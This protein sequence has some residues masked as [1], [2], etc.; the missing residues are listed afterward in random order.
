MKTSTFPNANLNA[1]GASKALDLEHE[2]ISSAYLRVGDIFE[3]PEGGVVPCD[4]ILVEGTA[5]IDEADVTGEPLPISKVPVSDT[6]TDLLDL[7]KHG[8]RHFLH[9]GTVVIQ[10]E[11]PTM[12]PVS[13]RNKKKL[14]FKPPGTAKTR[15]SSQINEMDD[16]NATQ[17]VRPTTTTRTSSTTAVSSSKSGA[18]GALALV[19]NVG[20]DTNKGQMIAKIMF[21]QAVKCQ[22]SDNLFPLLVGWSAI[23]MTF[24]LLPGIVTA[25]N[26]K[27]LAFTAMVDSIY[28]TFV[29]AFTVLNPVLL[30]CSCETNGYGIAVQNANSRLRPN[31]DRW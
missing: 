15:T 24:C 4:C 1:T 10:S 22:F 13:R 30:N 5:L 17:S 18:A 9:C 23:L 19:V 28:A 7:K 11:G 31:Q 20:C 29:V 16:Q 12:P 8:K 26:N 25:I 2:V 6:S 27:A 21:P 14:K 3:I